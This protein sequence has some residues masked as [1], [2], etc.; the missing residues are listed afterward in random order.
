MN[1]QVCFRHG[2]AQFLSRRSFSRCG[3]TQYISRW[4]VQAWKVLVVHLS[5]FRKMQYK[6]LKG[7]AVTC[8]A[9]ISAYCNVNNTEK[10]MEIF[11][12]IQAGKLDDACSI[13][14]RM[15]ETGFRLDRL[16]YKI[17]IS[18]LLK[19]NKFD[20]AC[21]LLKEMI[22][23]GIQPDEIISQ[24][25]QSGDFST[26]HQVMKHEQERSCSHGGY[27]WCVNTYGLLQS[28]QKEDIQSAMSLL[29]EMEGKEVI[30]NV[31]TYNAI[32]R[33]LSERNRL[34]KAFEIMDKM[35]KQNCNPNY[36][37]SWL[38]QVGETEKFEA[39][40]KRFFRGF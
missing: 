32:L 23:V 15:Q 5:Y 39:F 16:G 1:H 21:E 17:I 36:V 31:I 34:D 6:G 9:L 8:S 25:S 33:G 11:N 37:T 2:F 35:G 4:D 19:K 24:S 26:A 20:K 3:N 7:N 27:L 10:A 38:P 40:F 18:G 13:K 22:D 28:R 12:D 14:S 29:D 30:P